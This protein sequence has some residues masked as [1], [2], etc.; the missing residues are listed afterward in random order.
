MQFGLLEM[1]RTGIAC[2]LFE[3]KH[4]SNFACNLENESKKWFH[5]Y[6]SKS[7]CLE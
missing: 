1:S 7:K 4:L 6:I 3:L 2:S 5:I